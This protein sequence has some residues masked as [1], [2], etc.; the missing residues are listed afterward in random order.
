MYVEE[1]LKVDATT[2]SDGGEKLYKANSFFSDRSWM[3]YRIMDSLSF[4]IANVNTV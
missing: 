3:L 2:Q 1:N 4:Q